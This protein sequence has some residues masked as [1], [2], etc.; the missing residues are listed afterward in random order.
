MVECI[1]IVE[2]STGYLHVRGVGPCNWAQPRIG[3]LPSGR[4]W[5][6]TPYAFPQASPEFLRDADKAVEKWYAER[7]NP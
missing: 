3:R 7:R 4:E 2:L 1:T 5:D 6:G